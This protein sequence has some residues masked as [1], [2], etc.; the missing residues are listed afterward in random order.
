M[1]LFDISY[2]KFRSPVF[3]SIYTRVSVAPPPDEVTCFD[4]SKN[5]PSLQE[6]GEYYFRGMLD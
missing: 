2:M 6:K 3:L 1:I 5:L 4:M